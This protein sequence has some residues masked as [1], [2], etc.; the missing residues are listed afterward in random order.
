MK[1]E[2]RAARGGEHPIDPSTGA[3]VPP[4]HTSTTFARHPDYTLVGRASY[5]RDEAPSFTPAEELLASLEGG[6]AALL[7]P[8]G[9]A[10]MA[11]LLTATLQP[12]A[13]VVT[14]RVLYWG[15]RSWLAAFA[16][17]WQVEVTQVD[18]SDLAAL[19]AALRPGRTRWLWIETPANPSWEITDIA[20]AAAL[21]HQA[22]A[23][24]AV[25]STVA[26]PVFSRPLS[27]G[28]D[29]VMHSATKYLNGHGDVV[30]GALVTAR[31]DED[32]ALVR[33]HRHDAGVIV[34]PFE[35]WLLHRGLR[36][37]FPRVRRQAA[38]ALELATRLARVTRVRYPGLPDDPGHAV[39][40][41]QMHGG[42]GAMLSIFV[43][44][45]RERAL[46]VAGRMKLFVRATSLG[47]TES[48]VEHRRSVEPP[49][50]PVAPDL[51]RLSIGLE[52][53]EDLWED[54]EQALA[55]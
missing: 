25:D 15:A 23:R 39:A 47:G 22:G 41:Q 43:G 17:R 13:H 26:T 45:S 10:A 48:L 36:T 21:A 18:T 9:M 5:A 1:P 29:V 30:A 16:R 46:Q 51:L 49:D 19:E 20:A 11:A 2:T 27:L 38:T 32:W 7:F 3:L 12:G 35:A 50:S 28:A 14:S 53:V 34:G 33:A 40:S 37:L 52:D 8:S 55:G 42:Y 54:L 24:L 4:L 44:S 6:A 31:A